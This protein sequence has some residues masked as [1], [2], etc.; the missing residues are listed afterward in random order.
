ML[1]ERIEG[2]Y[3]YQMASYEMQRI[4]TPKQYYILH[5]IKSLCEANDVKI[6][7]LM[8]SVIFNLVNDERELN[9][10][11]M[12]AYFYSNAKDYF[13]FK[14]FLSSKEYFQLGDHFKEEAGYK[15]L[16]TF[17]DFFDI[18]T[19]KFM[20]NQTIRQDHLNIKHELGVKMKAEHFYIFYSLITIIKSKSI[21]MNQVT[22][23]MVST[24]FNQINSV[25]GQSGVLMRPIARCLKG[26]NKMYNK[27]CRSKDYTKLPS[28][29]R[30]KIDQKAS[31]VFDYYYDSEAKNLITSRF[32][33]GR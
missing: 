5:L 11:V 4:T 13:Q 27:W 10:N 3:R 21:D 29:F 26:D 31:E 18:S 9:S 23:R 14:N 25:S 32:P 33:L 1:V 22:A 19:G 28:T 7:Q 6:S 30:T 12:H 24:M 8:L 2:P 20:S 17:Y 16:I 15:V